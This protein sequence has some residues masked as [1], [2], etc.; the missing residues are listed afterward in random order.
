MKEFNVLKKN[1]KYYAALS[2]G[3]KCR[4]LI[5]EN[6]NSLQLGTQLL[7]VEDISVR[8]K[9]RVD[10][11]FKLQSSIEEQTESGVV[12]LTSTYNS[13]L[14]EKCRALGGQWDKSSQSWMFSGLIAEQVDELDYIFNS[15][16]IAVE[17]TVDENY[18]VYEVKGQLCCL[19]YPVARAFGRDSGAKVEDK[20]GILSG[21]FTSSGSVKNWATQAENGTVFRFEVAEEVYNQFREKEPQYRFKR[22]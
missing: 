19:G 10:R 5:D 14:V 6:S 12:T 3:Y 13:Y 15:S 20:I 1:R 2:N 4:I 17:V 22:L 11:V 18:D 7:D 21:G 8:S 16:K 9:Y